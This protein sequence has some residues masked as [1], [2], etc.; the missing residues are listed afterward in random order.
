M[1]IVAHPIGDFDENIIIND[2]YETPELNS[3]WYFLY[4]NQYQFISIDFDT[5]IEEAYHE[6]DKIFI[7]GFTP[8]GSLMPSGTPFPSAY[9]DFSKIVLNPSGT[10]Y[11]LTKT[12]KY[13]EL[14]DDLNNPYLFIPYFDSEVYGGISYLDINV[15]LPKIK[16]YLDFK[17]QILNGMILNFK[18]KLITDNMVEF[19]LKEKVISLL[20]IDLDL[21]SKDKI[22]IIWD[23]DEVS[24]VEILRRNVGQ[25]NY[26]DSIAVLPWNQDGYIVDF[27]SNSY[28]YSIRGK[29]GTG[30]SLNEVSIGISGLTSIKATIDLGDFVKIY[31]EILNIQTIFEIELMI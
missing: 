31:E 16:V 26:G 22:K 2:I 18:E 10:P 19:G 13:W 9:R 5:D 3:G 17:E 24:E 29:N 23:G 28:T 27:D 25:Q 15:N 8:I 11:L 21:I 12:N 30:T 7:T 14:F 1:T 6:G 20:N 4:N